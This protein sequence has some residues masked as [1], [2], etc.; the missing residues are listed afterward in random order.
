MQG[1]NLHA[2][3]LVRCCWSKDTWPRQQKCLQQI[4]Q[5]IQEGTFGRSTACPNAKSEG[6]SARRPATEHQARNHCPS[7]V[8][9]IV[10]ICLKAAPGKICDR[11]RTR[12]SLFRAICRA[13]LT[14]PTFPIESEENAELS[15][16]ARLAAARDVADVPIHA[17][18]YCRLSTTGGTR[19]NDAST[20]QN[21]GCCCEEGTPPTQ[22]KD[23]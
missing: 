20:S 19:G 14:L 5:L 1:C 17:S 6:A 7:T 8:K 9:L 22:G 16:S 11:I 10:E 3:L 2:M 12:V 23:E 4:W 13:E 18:C 21:A 15:L